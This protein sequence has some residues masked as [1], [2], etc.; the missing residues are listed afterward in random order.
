LEALGTKSE[1][2]IPLLKEQRELEA[3]IKGLQRR[4][5]QALKAQRGVGN[6]DRILIAHKG[7]V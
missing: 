1:E 6:Q 4:I 5:G 3:K 7:E 2:F